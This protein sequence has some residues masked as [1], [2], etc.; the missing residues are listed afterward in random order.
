MSRRSKATAV[1]L[2]LN[3]G[4][5][6]T[7]DFRAGVA[8][9]TRVELL[10]IAV[11][12]ALLLIMAFPLLA[13]SRLR[14]DRLVCANNLRRIGVAFHV[15]SDSHQ[16]R[17][18]WQV[19]GPSP[20]GGTGGV[21]NFLI[22]NAWYHFTAI[23]NELATPALLACPSDNGKVATTWDFGPGGFLN[24]NNRNNAL[25]YLVGCHAEIRLPNS[26]LSADRNILP[27]S[28]SQNCSLGFQ[29]VAAINTGFSSSAAWQPNS[30]HASFGNM[31]FTGGNVAELSGAGLRKAVADPNNDN[32]TEHFLLP[33]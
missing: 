18:P 14:S 4:R 20:D 8:A 16:D 6:E 17:V 11:A 12:V 13:N 7:R 10:F 21:G 30:M 31:L 24:A 22:N 25:S 5:N 19:S 32:G 9:F 23:S 33:R 1:P 15:W 27:D 2:R 28:N 3:V 26:V 29:F